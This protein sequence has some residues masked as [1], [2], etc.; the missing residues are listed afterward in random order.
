MSPLIRSRLESTIAA[1]IQLIDELC[2]SPTLRHLDT[3]YAH[4][5]STCS[6]GGRQS[7]GS[8]LSA[9]IILGERTT[10]ALL[11][12]L[13]ELPL[14]EV[15]TSLQTFVDARLL[16]TESPMELITENKT[17]RVGHP[18]LRDYVVNPLRC[19]MKN[20]LFDPAEDHR[21]IL[22]RCLWLLN[23]HL[24]PDICDIR[25]PGLANADIRDLPS[26]IARSLPDAVRYACVYWP[27]HLVSSG[28]LSEIVSVALLDFCMDHLLHWLEVLS[29]LG[30]LASAI[31]HL[32]RVISWCKVSMLP[33][34]CF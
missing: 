20:Y 17:L 11:A 3:L 22:D 28:P 8:I 19:L 26:R 9:L 6:S 15:T 18:S 34:R 12:A 32:P 27:V 30:E 10:P 33:A 13:F 5:L 25:D 16:T 7:N 1:G 29:L 14:N 4:V 24:R 2:R 31:K 21:K 23:K